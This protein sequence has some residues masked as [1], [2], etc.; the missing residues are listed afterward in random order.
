MPVLDEFAPTWVL[1]SAGYDGHRADPLANLDLSSGDFARIAARVAEFAPPGRLALFLEG[2]YNL[3]ALR[4]SVAATFSSFLG[5]GFD[6]EPSTN[7][8]VGAEQIERT[9]VERREALQLAHDVERA[10][11]RAR[12]RL[13]S[14]SEYCSSMIVFLHGVPE[15]AALWDKVRAEF[16]EETVAL[17]LPGFGCARPDGFGA[18]KDDYAAWLV[19][20]LEILRRAGRPRRPR[21][22][23]ALHV[24]RRDDTR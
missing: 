5:G 3:E 4:G 24:P 20:E 6:A 23:R 22:G 12:S 2:G 17:S 1:V 21:L 9:Q 11:S 8:G 14:E 16:D 7:G 10:E 19:G 15:T 13:A 18:T